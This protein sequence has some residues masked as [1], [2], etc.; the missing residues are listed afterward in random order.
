MTIGSGDDVDRLALNPNR[1]DQPFDEIGVEAP[2][3][4]R[5][6]PKA[7]CPRCYGRGYMGMEN[8]KRVECSCLVRPKAHVPPK[9]K[10]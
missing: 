10:K 9:V 3:M 6:Y 5:V 4:V 2:E 1:V 7:N 8:W